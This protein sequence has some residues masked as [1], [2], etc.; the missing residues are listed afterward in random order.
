MELKVEVEI[1]QCRWG[2][3]GMDR[4]RGFLPRLT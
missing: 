3:M 4:G 1:A 2:R